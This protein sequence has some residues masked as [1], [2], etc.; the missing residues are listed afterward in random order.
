MKH[1][2]TNK[3][4]GYFFFVIFLT[5]FFVFI[6]YVYY[7]RIVTFS[8]VDEFDNFVAAYFMLKKK[9][10]FSEIFHNR[11][12]GMVYLSYL[13]QKVFNPQTLYQLVLYHRL[14]IIF[15]SFFM[16]ILIIYKFR[17]AGVGFVLFYELIK[18]YSHGNLFQAES[19]IVYPLVYLL[20]LVFCKFQKKTISD[21]DYLLAGIF[22]FFII[23]MREP[24]IPLTLFIYILILHNKENIK[25]KYLSLIIFLFL[26]AATFLLMPLRDYLYQLIV[27]NLNSVVLNE[28][29]S[30]GNFITF[31]LKS[32]GYPIYILINGELNHSHLVL[33][34][35]SLVFLIALFYYG[36]KLKK[37][38]E[39]ILIILIMGLAAVRA[40]PPGRP[41]FAAY[42]MLPWQAIFIMTIFFLISNLLS[43]KK[44]N[45]LA[46]VL[47]FTLM[48]IFVFTFFS[49]RSYIWQKVNRDEVFNINYNRYYVNG[50]VV[51]ILSKS[52]DKLFVDGYDSLIFWQSGL[53]SSYKYTLYYPILKGIPYFSNERIQMFKESPPAFYFRDCI[54]NKVLSL[55]RFIADKYEFFKFNDKN[56]CLY[57]HKDKLRQISKNKLKEIEKF[58]YVL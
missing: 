29:G 1:Y 51:K 6:F 26:S 23:F 36:F 46:T 5:L 25:I 20:G 12:P 39:V 41:F 55:P 16:S 44:T 33:M 48:V 45:K 7:Q 31:F 30:S 9:I 50:E 11:Q 19:L 40:V 24:Y 53:D 4:I 56:S 10:L 32:F 38:K 8:F 15:F 57:I 17:F 13:I 52:T 49:P 43:I 34:G 27:V 35:L 14:F 28:I 58:K 47:T 37:I 2:L 3:Q 18:Y 22:A 54:A 42:K 21:K